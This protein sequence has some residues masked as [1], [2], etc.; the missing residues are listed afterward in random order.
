MTVGQKILPVLWFGRKADDAARFYTSIF[1]NSR[2]GGSSHYG[3]AGAKVSEVPEGSIMT[4]EFEI[5]KQSFMGLNGEPLFK[6]NPSISFLVACQ[7]RNEV[8]ALWAKLSKGGGPALM[9]LGAYPFS[10]RYGWTQD[11]YGLS[12]QVMLMGERETKQRI[13]PTLMFVGEQCGNAESA[14]KLYA[15]IF[16]NSAVGEI[17]RYGRDEGPDEE[18]TVKHAGFTLEGQQFAAMDSAHEYNFSFNEAIS[19]M[20]QCR[21]QEE[22]NYYWKQLT[23]R[24]GHEGVCGWLKDRLGVSWQVTPVILSEM[25][26]DPDKE[27]VER[28][29]RAFLKMKKFDIGELEKAYSG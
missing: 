20:V 7:A 22:I 2:L 9:E 21:N 18:G 1:K 23:A 11:R 26:R 14:V 24:G 17:M 15:G 8:D 4:V 19:F 13:I 16:G 27:K 3:E 6:F 25:M 5:E 29:T 10:E 12:W 28:V